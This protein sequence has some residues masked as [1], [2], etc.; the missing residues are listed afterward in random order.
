MC[1]KS[2]HSLGNI[3]PNELKHA[4]GFRENAAVQ[5]ALHRPLARSDNEEMAVSPRETGEFHSSQPT[6]S[7]VSKRRGPWVW[8]YLLGFSLGFA[9]W[10]PVTGDGYDWQSR[11]VLALLVGP[12]V[13]LTLRFFKRPITVRSVI[14][15]I[16][17]AL[18]LP[19]LVV[20]GVMVNGITWD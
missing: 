6:R 14:A 11:L 20:V 5:L 2:H 16:I 13:A 12:A 4:A 15:G 8:P 7:E 17:G 3:A 1:V 18:T 9:I 19:I 10:T